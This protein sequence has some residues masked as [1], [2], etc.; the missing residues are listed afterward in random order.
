[1]TGKRAGESHIMHARAKR[2]RS[3]AAVV[4]GKTDDTLACLR[5]AVNGG[6]EKRKDREYPANFSEWSRSL[7]FLG[8]SSLGRVAQREGAAEKNKRTVNWEGLL[9]HHARMQF[10]HGYLPTQ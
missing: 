1:M 3:R 2:K 10:F 7:Y 4:T 6:A 9:S 8:G 5:G